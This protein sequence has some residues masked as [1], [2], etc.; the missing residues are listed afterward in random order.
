MCTHVTDEIGNT[1][2]TTEEHRGGASI[3]RDQIKAL[4]GYILS[5][6][7]HPGRILAESISNSNKRDEKED[8]DI[9]WVLD[10]LDHQLMDIDMA[11]DFHTMS[12]LPVLVSLLT[13]SLH[14]IIEGDMVSPK[15][16]KERQLFFSIGSL[17]CLRLFNRYFLIAK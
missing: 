6:L 15:I 14:G 5:P 7:E 9:V 1:H 3:I 13:N 17:H 11:R 12:R 2:G 10:N 16:T 4:E 8:I